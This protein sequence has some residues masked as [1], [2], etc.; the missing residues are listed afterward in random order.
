M[1]SLR[2]DRI[3]TVLNRLG[4]PPHLIEMIQD[5][6]LVA[7]LARVR[8]EFKM[9]NDALDAWEAQNPYAARMAPWFKAREAWKAQGRPETPWYELLH[10]YQNPAVAIKKAEITHQLLSKYRKPTDAKTPWGSGRPVK[11]MKKPT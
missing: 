10:N 6:S 3:K 7:E 2:N 5:E 11:A 1:A 8:A 4:I 9:M